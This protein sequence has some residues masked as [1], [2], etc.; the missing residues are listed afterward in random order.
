MDLLKMI[1]DL[2]AEKQRLDEAIQALER[3]SAGNKLRRRGR[4]PR[5]LKDALSSTNAKADK[6]DEPEGEDGSS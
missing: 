6:D 5:W 4:P 3:L 1:N 2:Q